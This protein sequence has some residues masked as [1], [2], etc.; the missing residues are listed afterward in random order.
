[1]PDD[2][3][4]VGGEELLCL[5]DPASKSINAG[6][7]SLASEGRRANPP[8]GCGSLDLGRSEGRYKCA[9][10]GSGAGDDGLLALKERGSNK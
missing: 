7:L 1:V 2:W 5:G 10:G 9:I 4:P 8:L 3:Q 6:V